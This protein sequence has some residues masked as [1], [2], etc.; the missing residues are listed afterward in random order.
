MVLRFSTWRVGIGEIIMLRVRSDDH[1][2][3][4]IFI[5]MMIV[6]HDEGLTMSVSYINH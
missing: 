5:G 3:D 6:G 4:N 2:D 1:I